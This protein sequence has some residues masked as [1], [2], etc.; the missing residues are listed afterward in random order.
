MLTVIIFLVAASGCNKDDDFNGRQATYV[1]QVKDVLGV[2]AA[3]L[4]MNSAVEGGAVVITLDPVDANGKS[5]TAE[6]S[7][8]Y[9]QLIVYDGFIQVLKSSSEPDVI[10]VQ[11]DIGSNEQITVANPKNQSIGN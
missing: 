1:L 8:S 3:E 10:L 6:K 9:D 5:S 4:R 2:T 7:I 11:G